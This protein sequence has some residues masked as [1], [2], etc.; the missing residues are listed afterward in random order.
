MAGPIG[1]RRSRDF[2]A[3]VLQ[4]LQLETQGRRE[5]AQRLYAAILEADPVNSYAL[6]RRA[7]FT[8]GRGDD[9]E[10]LRLILAAMKRGATTEIVADCGV[11]LD[12]LG[13]S[14]EAI[15]AYDRA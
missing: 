8:A 7:I 2:R 5:E 1:K 9:V 12:R 3:E 4:G 11:I 10:A 14:D 6:Y 13:R 15:A